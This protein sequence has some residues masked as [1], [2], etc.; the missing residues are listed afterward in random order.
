MSGTT[1]NDKHTY[2]RS[3]RQRRPTTQYQAQATTNA[4]PSRLEPLLSY[5]ED[6]PSLSMATTNQNAIPTSFS[7]KV[8]TVYHISFTLFC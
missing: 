5:D 2:Y 8:Y 7:N 4:E 1:P 3:R 6:F